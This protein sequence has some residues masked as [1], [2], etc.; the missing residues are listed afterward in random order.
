MSFTVSI[1][2]R[3]WLPLIAGIVVSLAAMAASVR[4]EPLH[5]PTGLIEAS[6]NHPYAGFSAAS[7]QRIDRQ[8]SPAPGEGRCGAVLGH[9]VSH[10]PT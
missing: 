2:D 9:L 7:R 3:R 10:L 1:H 6:P 8:L 4:S 5:P